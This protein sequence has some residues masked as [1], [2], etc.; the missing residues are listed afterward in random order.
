[1]A[2][3]LVFTNVFFVMD[4]T[5]VRIEQVWSNQMGKTWSITTTVK[6]QQLIGRAAR[7]AGGY[8]QLAEKIA[9]RREEQKR[10]NK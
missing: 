2:N 5:L 1:M 4:F 8:F 9:K 3:I 7:A 10:E 6:Q